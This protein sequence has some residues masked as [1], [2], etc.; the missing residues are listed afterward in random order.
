LKNG[1]RHRYL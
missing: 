1:K